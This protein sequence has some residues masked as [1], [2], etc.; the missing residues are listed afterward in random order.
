MKSTKRAERRHHNARL[1]K[2]RYDREVREMY[3]SHDMD[4]EAELDWCLR[5]ARMRVDTNT[6]CSCAMCGNPRRTWGWA[7][8]AVVTLQEYR[9]NDAFTD[10]LLDYSADPDFPG[11]QPETLTCTAN[12]NS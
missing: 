4:M 1:L 9:A 5:R 3:R 12:T 7:S 11:Q 10:G 2:N 8:Y 6:N